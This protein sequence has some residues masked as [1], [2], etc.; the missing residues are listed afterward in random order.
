[1]NGTVKYILAWR[2]LTPPSLAIVSTYCIKFILFLSYQNGKGQHE[3]KRETLLFQSIH[4]A[5]IKCVEIRT[6]LYR[7]QNVEALILCTLILCCLVK[8]L[9]LVSLHSPKQH[10]QD[11][12]LYGE[13]CLTLLWNGWSPFDPHAFVWSHET[14][15]F[16]GIPSGCVCTGHFASIS[17]RQMLIMCHHLPVASELLQLRRQQEMGS[18]QVNVADNN[19]INVP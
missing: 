13:N 1:M 9:L 17:E 8:Q 16:Q 2:H 10:Q 3:D 18:V 5:L 14:S 7:T 6:F 12:N 4:R 15:S 11:S 19:G